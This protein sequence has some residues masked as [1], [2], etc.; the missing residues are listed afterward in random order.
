MVRRSSHL[1]GA[2][3]TTPIVQLPAAFGEP[4]RL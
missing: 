2:L 3:A 1:T 4:V